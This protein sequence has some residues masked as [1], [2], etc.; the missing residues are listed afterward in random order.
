MDGA[1]AEIAVA[2]VAAA[3]AAAA[4][5]LVDE[6]GQ[7]EADW[8]HA[9]FVAKVRQPSQPV[10]CGSQLVAGTGCYL[11]TARD[12]PLHADSVRPAATC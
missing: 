3:R 1:K 4:E 10:P 2:D 12:L 7:A 11:L 9:S 8:N 5:K 6:M